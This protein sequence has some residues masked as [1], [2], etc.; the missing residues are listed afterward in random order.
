M[1]RKRKQ[2]VDRRGG[3]AQALDR[4]GRPRGPVQSSPGGGPQSNTGANGVDTVDFNQLR[5]KYGFAYAVIMSDPELKALFQKAVRSGWSTDEFGARLQ[6]TRWYRAH[7]DTWRAMET[8]RLADP[9]TWQQNLTRFREGLRSQI[10]N[11]GGTVPGDFDQ[12][13]Q[14]LYMSGYTGE[15]PTWVIAPYVSSTS[16]AGFL[17]DAGES[18][19]TLREFASLNGL[20]MG[21]DWFR[22]AVDGIVDG[23]TTLSDQLDFLR[24][25]AMEY[26]PAWAQ[27]IQAGQTA[28]SLSGGYRQRMADILEL[29]A[30]QITLDDQYVRDAMGGG[31]TQDGTYTPMSM[32]DFERALRKDPRFW[33]TTRARTEMNSIAA[34]VLTDFGF[35]GLS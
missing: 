32:G 2:Q 13:A 27:Q 35:G 29:N 3:Y 18:E 7:S 14:D 10:V 5:A 17:G 19:D 30:D 33:G 31:A 4:Q 11:A 1:A 26:W 15:V 24:R 25:R 8:Q 20:G 22:N 9:A 28:W 34:Q 23:R 21:D 16:D 12:V 6:D